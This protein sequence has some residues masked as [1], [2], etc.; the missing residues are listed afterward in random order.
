MLLECI[1]L[2]DF[3]SGN[4]CCQL[5]ASEN[6]D[7]KFTFKFLFALSKEPG[8]CALLA[9]KIWLPRLHGF[10]LHRKIRPRP[11]VQSRWLKLPQPECR[12][13]S[14]EIAISSRL[15]V[16]GSP[17]VFQTLVTL[18]EVKNFLNSSIVGQALHSDHRARLGRDTAKIS[19]CREV[20]KTIR[21]TWGAGIVGCV[22]HEQ[23]SACWVVSSGGLQRPWVQEQG[24]LI[25]GSFGRNHGCRSWEC[26]GGRR[27][28]W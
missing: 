24:R 28:A 21:R 5:A 11:T 9:V 1:L 26:V 10:S 23:L 13:T 12:Q 4:K 14:P 8:S 19:S 15:I 16:S 3:S 18:E 20:A 2:Q 27:Q 17:C 6:F 22:V 7:F 25:N